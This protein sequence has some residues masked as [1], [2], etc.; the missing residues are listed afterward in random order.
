MTD[1]LTE[2]SAEAETNGAAAPRADINSVLDACTL[3]ELEDLE[4]MCGAP[5]DQFSDA[6]RPKLKLV[7][8]V[9]TILKQRENPAFTFEETR[10]MRMSEVEA[11]LVAAV[12]TV[13]QPG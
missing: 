6:A 12:P 2:V 8:A 1:T 11:I 4:E 5:I 7:R 9:V 3:G 13:G 10:P